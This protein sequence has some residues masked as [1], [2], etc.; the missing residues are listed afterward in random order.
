MGSETPGIDRKP[1]AAAPI[2]YAPI[3]KN[4]KGAW[5]YTLTDKDGGLVSYKVVG[6]KG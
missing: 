1:S 6:K 3:Y 2:F 5:I 4:S